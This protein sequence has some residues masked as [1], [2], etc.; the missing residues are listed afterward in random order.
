MCS[1]SATTACRPV[2]RTRHG[3]SGTAVTSASLTVWAQQNG[4]AGE[5]G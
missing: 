4:A 1:G 5:S 3:P 2:H